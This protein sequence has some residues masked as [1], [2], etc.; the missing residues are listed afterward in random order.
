VK[1]ITLL[2]IVLISG[3]FLLSSASADNLAPLF[4]KQ[5]D[6]TKGKPNVYSNTF[7]AVPGEAVLLVE[8]GNGKNLRTM[9]NRA[10][11]WLNGT[12][13][14]KNP[15]FNRRGK[16]LKTKVNLA[17]V[18]T[19][20]V[21]LKGRS[22]GFLTIKIKRDTETPSFNFKKYVR[23]KKGWKTA[24]K[25]IFSA[26]PGEAVLV[27]ENGNGQNPG[28]MV[29]W[30]GIWLNGVKLF[31]W[32]E[33]NKKANRLE[34]KVNLAETNTLK[35]FLIGRPGSFL[36]I[37]LKND[38]S[39][40]PSVSLSADPLSIPAG[41][42]SRLTWNSTNTDTVS[43]D[44]GIGMVDLNG[45]VSVQPT[46][47]TTYMITAT[48]AGGTV[49]ES[50]T[51]TVIPLP[52]VSLS[53]DPTSITAGGSS[54]LT[55]N[56]T[57]AD[58]VSIDNGIGTVGLSG[59]QS[60][61]PAA[62]TTYTITATGAGG[63]ATKSVTITVIPL[64]SVSLSAVPA[65]I[66]AGGSSTLSWSST[67]AD[68]VSIDNGIGSVDLSG[69]VSVQPTA[70]TTYTITATGAGGTV[71]ES[72]TI[73]V[74]PLPTVSLSADPASIT[75]GGSSTL[76]WSSTNADSVS[77]DNGIG[78]VDLSGSVSVQLTATTTYTI[79]ATGAGG[80]VTESVTITVIPLPSVSL[81]AAPASITAGGSST[82][83]W[84]STNADS[85]SIT[86][87]IGSVS[88]R[89]TATVS[90]SATTVYTITAEGPGG[91]ATDTVTIEVLAP[92]PAVTISADPASITA[93]GNSLLTWSSTN[94]D[95]V[96]ITPDI[97]TVAA[98][99]TTTVT[100]SATTTYT[101]TA[102]GSGGTATDTATVEV[103]QPAPTVTISADPATVVAGS[104]S[105]LSWQSTNAD[106]VSIDNGIGAVAGSGSIS[107]E[108]TATTT[109]T[110][111]ATGPGGTATDTAT[112]EV[113][114]PVP[115]VTIS[116][117]P[118]TITS[119]GSSQLTWSSTNADSVS[120]TPDVGTVAASGTASVS[121]SATTTYTIT[122]T[123]PGGTATDTVTVEV[124]P[125]G[126]IVVTITA[127][128]ETIPLGTTTLLSWQ[129]SGVAN[130]HIDK[131]IGA[132]SLNDSLSVAPDHTTTYTITGSGPAGTV[133][134]Q[135]TVQ[136]QGSPEPQPEGSFGTLYED[137]VPPDATVTAYD[138]KRFSLITGAVN[139]MSGLP[140]A[141]VRIIVH[142]HPEY[143][144]V[145]TDTDGR[146][147]IP[148]DGGG[149]ITIAYEHTGFIT[150]HRQVYVPWN[151]IAITETIQMVAE[152]PVATTITFDGNPE[153][154]V[155]HTSTLIT[156]EFG[157]R[158]AT[159]VFQGDNMAYLVDEEGNDVQA[160]ST[161]T[162]RA[163][164][165]ATPESM[166]AVLPPN[167]AYTYC[168]ELAV[169]GAERVRFAKPVTI[170]VDN[171]LGFDVGEIVPVGYYDRDRGVWVPSDNGVVVRLLD[172]DSDGVV[173]ALD[174]NGDGQPDDLNNDGSFADEVVGLGDASRY[175]PGT[176]FWR[177]AVTHFTPWDLN[178]PWGPPADAIDPNP[179]GVPTVETSD[180]NPS[181]DT[182]PCPDA[183]NDKESISSYVKKRG[184]VFHEDIPIPG[185]DMTLH[186]AS[187]R[188]KGY[189]RA[190]TVPV[191]GATVPAS[192]KR[193]EVKVNIAGR[194][195]SETLGPLPNQQ[196]KFVWDGLDHLGRR[197]G[198]AT[199]IIDVGFVYDGFLYT[200]GNTSTA[201]GQTGLVAT[202]VPT[203]QETTKWLHYQQP[204]SGVAGASKGTIAGGWTLSSHHAMLSS[205]SH[206]NKGDGSFL[207]NNS[208]II[209]T[210][211]GGN[212]FPFPID[213][214]PAIE[215]GLYY[216]FDVAVDQAGN[217]IIADSWNHRIRKVDT[218]GIITTIAGN[219]EWGFSGDGGPATEATLY[220]P[221]SVVVDQAGNIFFTDT[222][223]HMSNSDF[224]NNRIRKVD[225]NGIIS[226]VAGNGPGGFSG[227][228]GPATEASLN[229]PSGVAVDQAGNIF[230]AD[231]WNH[232]IR[233][234][235]TAGI[236]TT[237]AGGGRGYTPE[238]GPATARMLY[239]PTGVAVD[240]N[241]NIFIAEG[242][243]NCIRKV[244]TT[245]Y[246]TTLT[247]YKWY[248]WYSQNRFGGD[249]GPAT[250]ALLQGP[251]DVTVD[252]S[253]NIFIADS[254]NNRIRKIDTAGII[255]TVA[256]NGEKVFS[257]DNGPATEAGI[258]HPAGGRAYG[259]G[260]DQSGN[261]LIA[262]SG[263]QRVRK[264]EAAS[265]FQFAE[266]GDISI[267]DP[268]G[269]GYIMSPTGLHKKTISLDTDFLLRE[270]NYDEEDRLI[271]ITDQFG[272]VTTIE[273]LADGTPTAIISPDGLRTE[274]HINADN[275][276]TQV[277]Y[278]DNSAY[279]FT[280]SPDGLMTLEE[281]PNG[282]L[283]EHIF[284]ENGHIIE[285]RDQEG[286]NWQYSRQ[287][288]S[289]GEVQ[290]DSVTAEGN[291]ITILDNISSTGAFSTTTIDPSGN[292]ST[293][294]R[295]ADGLTHER[296]L[297]CGMSS[298]SKYGL[299]PEYKYKTLQSTTTQSPTGLTKTTAL[300]KTSQD[301]NTDRIPDQ[302]TKT[303]TSNGKTTILVHNTL[304]AEKTIT[305]PEGR[306]V[307]SH[308]DP[309]TLLTTEVSV[310]GLFPTN[311]EYDEKGRL[312]SVTSDS[313]TV[314][315]SYTGRGNILASQTDPEG[316][317]TSYTHDPVG[318][319]TGLTRPDNST[320]QF[321]YDSN[322][323]MTVLTNPTATDHGFGYNKVNNQNAY[324]TPFSGSYTYL[325]DK[326]RRL[327]Q[328][329]YPSGFQIKNL[330]TDNLLTQTQTPEGDINYSYLCSSKLG[331]IS[332][333]T[334]SLAYD[335]DGS[336]LLTE[337]KNGTLN[338][339][340]E[341]SYNN[342]FNLSAISYAGETENLSYDKDGLLIGAGAYTLSRNADNGLPEQ[343]SGNGLN[344]SRTFNGHGE[345]TGEEATVNAQPVSG[346]S[347]TRDKNGRIM[348][349]T[350][351]VN[352][353]PVEY[354]YSYD[355][356]GRLLTVTKDGA[357]VEEYRYGL[358]GNRIYE[359]NALKGEA[360]RTYGYSTEDHLLEAGGAV[361]DYD[362]DGFLTRKTEGTE[363]TG[364]RYSS[365]GE[366]LEV[367]LPNGDRIAYLHDPLGRRIAKKINGSIVEKYLWLGLTRLLAVY[368]GN[369]NLLMRFE[370]ADGRMP[371]AM[372]TGGASYYLAYDQVGSLRTVSDASGN[373]VKA[374]SYD[375]FGTILSDSNP[376][377]ALPFGFAGG[378][379]DR[380]TGLVK[381]GFRDYD[382]AIGRWVAKDPI[383]FAGGNVDLYGYVLNDPVNFVDPEGL[384]AECPA[385]P[386]SRNDSDWVAYHG[387]SSVFHCGFRGFHEN[388][389]PTPNDPIGECFYD[390]NDNLVDKDHEYSECRGTPNYYY[391]PIRHTFIDPGGIRECGSGAYIESFRYRLEMDAYKK[392]MGTYNVC[393]GSKFYCD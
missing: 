130:V 236:I 54:T 215:S 266:T 174:A 220:S 74:I 374:I 299:D 147:T 254:G 36:T 367:A 83:S 71:T 37:R 157:S 282:N 347:V 260:L 301:T 4:S 165:F 241:G 268:N 304:D 187:N 66:T 30:A 248:N 175:V 52:T 355:T 250:E 149:T 259:I 222:S 240:Q 170:W 281:E 115:I 328:T 160:L 333:G 33:F 61:S 290:I 41:G 376:A 72:L 126:P 94:A 122:A 51:I 25:D 257:G 252:Q 335:Y 10:E 69:S 42:S 183:P 84:S 293:F 344:R 129:A 337:T 365:R 59:T 114:Q 343:L 322:G 156:D 75:A 385:R 146:F 362:A 13:L 26:T 256:G 326:D 279:N 261:I 97:G 79:T 273:R 271:S 370:Y 139:D 116:A 274:L 247:R 142:S 9:L 339:V 392:L 214:I 277:S 346:W 184:R 232:R 82:L 39:P 49:S 117:D 50:V 386:P 360:G 92:A 2:F 383:F 131:G 57:N 391:D 58:T 258:G 182:Q 280:Y 137:L 171:F 155:A 18:N 185:T 298:T 101:I 167:S 111:T 107:V 87:D 109:Y 24:Y 99:G 164:E 230:I 218:N 7:Y 366:L 208:G 181:D 199:A 305:S 319:V 295:S 361:Y 213:N 98:S 272:N 68:S 351:T 233:K 78:S 382:P 123:G 177:A 327:V 196:A 121:P 353:S 163:T 324:Q 81:S 388:R 358:N 306:T 308:Y 223:K 316:R 265:R 189:G 48:G 62:T 283:F 373:V 371:V 31:R 372:T 55:W 292:E 221:N 291:R 331:T 310:P 285:V 235:D 381:F 45:S 204:I 253:G 198:G 38:P 86:P 380:D 212:V 136:V 168:A 112:V 85:V 162:T 44:N 342:D 178:W 138:A 8:N 340:L 46:A 300:D 356:M 35:V 267:P 88:A 197:V 73:T 269:L 89:G 294:S 124:L 64:P 264:V 216:P 180:D 246:L 20:K 152:D 158:S 354:S 6:R 150:S 315:L 193:I 16:H 284:D 188:V 363:V 289:S 148:V 369:D 133:S 90:P 270:F 263:N 202:N 276:L 194:T 393:T 207:K 166:P 27:V 390:D 309:A 387:D 63:T 186:Y 209:T 60:V 321:S 119:G 173:D 317:T 379:H 303:V 225:I 65:S 113:S 348:T 145:L 323:N 238:G 352:G 108:P 32:Y 205:Y 15:D 154:V 127:E 345:L 219:G 22:K 312:T 332:K 278:P 53:A 76:S 40:L 341:F 296:T 349:K 161:V 377:L 141:D 179:E 5:Y 325:Y 172:T 320:V 47:T 93:G 251:A 286:G 132:V 95:S 336:L 43:I 330:Y 120:I 329:N 314:S 153:T 243:F 318:R 70:T 245:G 210:V 105:V 159:M 229:G 191:S 368:D 77:I 364:Y 231:R 334:E 311:Y 255:T 103:S 96:S 34:V 14:F 56:S 19:L 151:D 169:D 143:G 313:R 110:I 140:L 239:E 228:N 378:L 134:S 244:D 357:L 237:V 249:N 338:Q 375:S 1:K 28:T 190:I 389:T 29:G 242:G 224:S 211:A 234:I 275:H 102:T 11:I 195:L 203:L 67:N 262:D 359:M 104:S 23:T 100:P 125:S 192:L 307:T 106:T 80:T 135:V 350:E 288:L 91:T 302:I 297:S 3:C 384:T 21:V 128:P 144:T 287:R 12:K 201:F 17:R 227:D 217:I 226:T 118:V 206:L 176:T 200:A